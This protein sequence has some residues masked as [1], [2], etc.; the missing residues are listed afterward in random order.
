M[1]EGRGYLFVVVW[2]SIHTLKIFFHK[3]DTELSITEDIPDDLL[4]SAATELESS[5]Q[6]PP[7]SKPACHPQPQAKLVT[8]LQGDIL[9]Q[10]YEC[11]LT[12]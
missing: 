12:S 5:V 8:K 9:L 7:S 10:C 6:V 2:H 11:H 1:I 4:L 3:T